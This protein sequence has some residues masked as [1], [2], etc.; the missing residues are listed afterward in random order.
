MSNENTHQCSDQSNTGYENTN[1]HHGIVFNYFESGTQASD[2]LSLT[3]C[4]HREPTEKFWF[5]GSDGPSAPYLYSKHAKYL[6]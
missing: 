4:S 1:M 6:Q 2:M 5:P 3:R